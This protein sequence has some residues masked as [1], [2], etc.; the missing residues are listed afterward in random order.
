VS[1]ALRLNACF[2]VNIWQSEHAKQYLQ[3]YI[4]LGSGER[5]EYLGCTPSG[6]M[7][8]LCRAGTELSNLGLQ[9]TSNLTTPPCWILP[10]YFHLYRVLVEYV[11]SSDSCLLFRFLL[12]RVR[13]F[14][15]CYICT[16]APQTSFLHELL[17][18][19]L[20]CRFV[21]E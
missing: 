9:I 3:P 21:T 5:Y 12:V 16:L 14:V 20:I 15:D 8:M 4:N 18:I 17:C 2:E 7:S 11:R 10:H 19:S 6:E 13:V 1:D